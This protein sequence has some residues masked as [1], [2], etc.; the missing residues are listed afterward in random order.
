M[1]IEKTT[2]INFKAKTTIKWKYFLTSKHWCG[3]R[4]KWSDKY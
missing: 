4:S 1:N 3:Y 2:F